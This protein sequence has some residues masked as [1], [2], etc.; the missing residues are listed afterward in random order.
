MIEQ[1]ELTKEQVLEALTPIVD[2][3]LGFNIIDLG[4]VYDIHIENGHVDVDMVLTDADS[5][6]GENLYERVEKTVSQM[7]GVKQAAVNQVSDP[8]WTEDRIN[9]RIRPELGIC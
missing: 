6:T 1:N 8:P 4:L 9:P 5:G 2:P 7:D 3:D